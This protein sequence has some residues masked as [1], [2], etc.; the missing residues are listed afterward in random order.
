[1][2]VCTNC[3][4]IFLQRRPTGGVSQSLSAEEVTIVRETKEE[5]A[6]RGGFIRLFPSEDSW[7]LYG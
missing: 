6:R 7:E 2:T 5:Y 3:S 4:S 1:M